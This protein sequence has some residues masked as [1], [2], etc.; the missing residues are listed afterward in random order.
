[1][2]NQKLLMMMLSRQMTAKG[3]NN[4]L[5]V[6]WIPSI[7]K[8]CIFVL[9]YF[10]LRT[11][12]TCCGLQMIDFLLGKESSTTQAIMAMRYLYSFGLKC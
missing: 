9:C 1:M 12:C 3:K 7:D 6:S 5:S 11:I 4:T 2:K 10:K 8:I